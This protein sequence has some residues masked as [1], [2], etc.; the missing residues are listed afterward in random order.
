MSQNEEPQPKETEREYEP[1]PDDFEGNSPYH[2]GLVPDA[3]E[4]GKDDDN[5]E[6]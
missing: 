6:K 2:G 4:D 1:K 3:D 5:A